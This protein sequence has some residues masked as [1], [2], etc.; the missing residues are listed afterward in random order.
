MFKTWSTLVHE[1]QRTHESFPRL[2]LVDRQRFRRSPANLIFDRYDE[3]AGVSSQYDLCRKRFFHFIFFVPRKGQMSISS[4]TESRVTYISGIICLLV[5][6]FH[7]PVSPL[8]TTVNRATWKE[9]QIFFFWQKKR[10]EKIYPARAH[11][12]E[13]NG[14][15]SRTHVSWNLPFSVWV[16]FLSLQF[17]SLTMSTLTSSFPLFKEKFPNN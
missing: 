9:N 13:Q 5:G 10:K 4:F 2:C 16:F 15:T 8:C 14:V 6:T 11:T 7:A 1:V 17:M 12:F 3:A